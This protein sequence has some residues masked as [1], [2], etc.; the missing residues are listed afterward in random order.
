[1][2]ELKSG[3]LPDT[4]PASQKEKDYQL[5][6]IVAG[7]NPVNWTEKPQDQ[8]RSFPIFN[9]DG[10]G[11]CVAQTMAKLLGILYWLKNKTYVHFSA[12]HIYQRRANKPA[13]GMAG[14]DAFTI[15]QKGVTLEQLVPSQDMTD[16]QMDAAIIE[17]YKQDVGTVFKI[18]NYVN[19][20]LRDI[21]TVASTIQTTQKGVM[22]WFYFTIDE[23]TP[24]PE[25]RNPNLDQY[26]PNVVRH[27]V[28]ATDFTLVNGKKCLII[29]DSWGTSYG[30]AGRRV[31]TEDFFKARNFFTAYPIAFVFDE[32]QPTKP[33]YTFN[34]NL[35]FGMTHPDVRELQKC[36]AYE[37]LFPQNVSGS[38][39]FGAITLKAV[40]QFQVKYAIAGP[41]LPGY[42]SVGPKTRSKLNELFGN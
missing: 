30:L 38:D 18:P 23:W 19:L 9:Q 13:S 24:T 1:M 3:A 20:P 8:W 40:Q 21:E 4:R 39:Y 33:H 26:A 15:A 14:V 22:V 2:P 37:G 10:S 11:S 5:R 32:P 29:E 7:V 35:S 12:T 36:L 28:T 16:G 6:E 25:I 27:S 17:Q 41:G 31:I 42:G 34:V